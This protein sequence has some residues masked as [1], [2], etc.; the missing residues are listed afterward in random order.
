MT[1]P[2]AIEDGRGDMPVPEYAT[3][4]TDG[5][6]WYCGSWSADDLMARLETGTV[7]IVPTDKNYKIY[8]R[9]DGGAAFVR[10]LRDCP[11]GSK[12]SGPNEC[13]HWVTREV[14]QP[15]FYFQHLSHDQKLRFIEL[16]NEKRVK[17]VGNEG[18]YVRPFF[19]SYGETQ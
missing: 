8:L 9:N 19:I 4:K 18:F 6:C 15:K 1:C 5:V 3:K 10:S 11:R 17:F 7:Q 16:L 14:E 13:E 2:R 12:C